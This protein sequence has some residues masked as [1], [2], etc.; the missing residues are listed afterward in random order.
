MKRALAVVCLL[1]LAVSLPAL[2]SEGRGHMNDILGHIGPVTVTGWKILGWIGALCFGGRWA[3]QW[4]HRKR[5]GRR[6]I[7]TVFWII[8]LAGAVMV[9]MYFIWGKN[10]SVGILTNAL[11]ATVAFW[12][13]FQDL[14]GHKKS[15]SS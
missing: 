8:S 2:E 12:N 7:P 13:L 3:V 15:A 9:T 1:L 5:T 6:E 14:R 4:W 10:D 11:P